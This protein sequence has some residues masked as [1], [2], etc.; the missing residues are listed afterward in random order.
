MVDDLLRSS[1]TERDLGRRRVLALTTVVG[2]SGVVAVGGLMVGLVPADAGQRQ[3]PQVPV[4][5]SDGT[6]RAAQQQ[7]VATSG[8]S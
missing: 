3:G 5:A 6:A 2:L 1:A 7:P 4:P 8:S